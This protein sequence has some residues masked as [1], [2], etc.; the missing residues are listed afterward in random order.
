MQKAGIKAIPIDAMKGTG[1]NKIVEE[2]KN[3][4]KDMMDTLK[5][6]GRKERAIR[7]MIVGIPNVGKSTLINKL[8]GRKSTVLG[9]NL[10]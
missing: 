1:V 10:V 6:K 8:T 3:A 7:I 2:C 5:Q 4:A 9:T